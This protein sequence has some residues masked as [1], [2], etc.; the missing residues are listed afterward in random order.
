MGTEIARHLRTIHFSLV[1]ACILILISLFVSSPTKVKI[2]HNQL[3]KILS[4][5]TN[6]NTWTRGFC[7]EQIT[8]LKQHGLT[9]S[10][11]VR[12][13][14]Y[15]LPEA[16]KKE[17]LPDSDHGW[18]VLPLYSPIYFSL[19]VQR[20]NSGTH[21]EII[22]F[23]LIEGDT[24]RIIPGGGTY[25]LFGPPRLDTLEDFRH[26]WDAANYVETFI[27]TKFFDVAYLISDDNVKTELRLNSGLIP[28]TG[29]EVRVGRRGHSGELSKKCPS[30]IHD[31]FGSRWGTEFNE[32]FC[33][34]ARQAG[35]FLFL[36]A[37]GRSVDLP[38]N[39]RIWLAEEFNFPTVSGKFE[40]TFP[41]LNEITKHYQKLELN[42]ANQI[43]GAE[44]QRTGERIEFLG[45][46]FP[47]SFISTW[48]AVIL[49]IIQLYF[50]LHLR[51]F[52]EYLA[53]SE[54]GIDVA[55]IGIYSDFWSRVISLITI[56]LLPVVIVGYLVFW[57]DWFSWKSWFSWFLIPLFM[58]LELLLVYSSAI[59]MMTHITSNHTRD[60]LSGWVNRNHEKSS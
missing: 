12:S 47:E 8:W 17:N 32:Y 16:L 29:T 31:L 15:I 38:T 7:R 57:G 42:D 13:E 19:S 1:L 25:E 60:L 4:I 6:W 51:T 36:P 58:V 48:G 44:L 56:S 35:E 14:F 59:M 28:P 33:G 10:N 24:L 43:L 26:F 53:S 46:K 54:T 5:N 22:G 39:L 55:W 11:T 23:G 3:Q 18:K 21:S 45:L 41:E 37:M 20:P 52:Y 34:V 50:W 30:G 2:A 9:W 49:L 27:V 40:E